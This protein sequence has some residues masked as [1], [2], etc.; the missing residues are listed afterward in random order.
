MSAAASLTGGKTGFPWILRNLQD[1]REV[2]GV[3]VA[4]SAGLSA[5]RP[6]GVS[7]GRRGS[8]QAL[9]LQLG[10]RAPSATWL[11][12]QAVASFEMGPC[13]PP[14]TFPGSCSGR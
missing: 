14:A 7:R 5:K 10:V 13:C 2:P 4:R 9:L 3:F 12:L 11:S 1:P 8:W 6:P